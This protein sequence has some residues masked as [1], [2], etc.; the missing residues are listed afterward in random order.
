MVVEN[1]PVV[2]QQGDCHV[3]F[4][5][6]D[7]SRITHGFRPNVTCN[8]VFKMIEMKGYKGHAL[9]SHFPKVGLQRDG[10][11]LKEVLGGMRVTLFVED[12][13]YI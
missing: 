11:C 3:V 9:V 7:G 13:S 1:T 8:E 10:Q 4:R 5:L 6:P 12:C 2:L